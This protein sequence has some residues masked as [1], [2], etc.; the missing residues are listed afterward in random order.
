MKVRPMI[1][2]MPAVISGSLAEI[3]VNQPEMYRV[4]IQRPLLT[5]ATRPMVLAYSRCGRISPTMLPETEDIRILLGS[6]TKAYFLCRL[7][8]ENLIIAGETHND[9][10]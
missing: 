1:K 5:T 2:A 9:N 6:R 10:W 8:G 4:K 3:V 7:E